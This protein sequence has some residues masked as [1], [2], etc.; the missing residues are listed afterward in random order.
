M[1]TARVSPRPGARRR[2][3]TA[4]GADSPGGRDRIANPRKAL[5]GGY[6][7]RRSS[8]AFGGLAQ[9]NSLV[10]PPFAKDPPVKVNVNAKTLGL[11]LLILGAI[12]ILVDAL[13]LIGILGFC[14]TYSIY[15]GCNLPI[16]WL[17]GDLIGLAAVIVGTIGAYRMYQLDP[18]GKQ[19]VV[20]GLILGHRRGR[21]HPD[22]QLRRVQ[23]PH[24][25]RGRGRSHLRPHHR[26]D[27]LRHPVLPGRGEPVPRPGAALPSRPPP[28][29]AV[30]DHR[31][32]LHRRRRRDEGR[33]RLSPGPAPCRGARA[34]GS[35]L[36]LS[37]AVARSAAPR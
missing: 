35:G 25:H 24:R 18:E 32:P 11:V 1:S 3:L 29:G 6:H 22:R 2:R 12:G 7:R 31:L 36:E 19:L 37:R 27:H 21:R 8:S 28:R 30:V 17:L 23:R 34:L 5:C 20:Y 9:L 14:G 16:L 10:D 15:G 4:R 13:A 33:T 26:P